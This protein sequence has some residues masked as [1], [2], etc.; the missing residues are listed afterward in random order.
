MIPWPKSLPPRDTISRQIA[1]DSRAVKI[2]MAPMISTTR[3]VT[4][5]AVLALSAPALAQATYGNARY[6]YFLDIPPGFS[7]V[8]ES[9]NGDGGRSSSKDGNATLVVWGSYLADRTFGH[10]IAWR[11]DQDRADGWDVTYQK[12]Q[13]GWAVWSGAKDGRIFYARAVPLCA[14]AVAYVRLEYAKADAKAFDPLVSRMAKSLRGGA[15]R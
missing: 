8:E 4:A 3:L 1:G 14:G 12:E 13:R 11:A 9:G 5:L 15:C 7:R 6:G 2:R 10:E